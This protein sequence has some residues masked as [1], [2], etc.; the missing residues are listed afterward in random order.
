MT[1]TKIFDFLL[2]ARI[3]QKPLA[4]PAKEYRVCL[5]ASLGHVWGPWSP[6]PHEAWIRA[7]DQCGELLKVGARASGS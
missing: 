5:S 6:T 1:E 4:M 7:I 2:E 3:T